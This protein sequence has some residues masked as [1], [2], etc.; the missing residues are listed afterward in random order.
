M[1]WR[2]RALQLSEEKRQRRDAEVDHI[3]Q[4]VKIIPPDVI[5]KGHDY[6][7]G[8]LTGW[9]AHEQQMQLEAEYREQVACSDKSSA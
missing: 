8:W 4:H 7:A 6:T 9:E 5:R 1:G 3:A 2:E